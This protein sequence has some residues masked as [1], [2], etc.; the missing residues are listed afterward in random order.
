MADEAGSK[1]EDLRSVAQ[2]ALDDA[3]ELVRQYYREEQFLLC[4]I[5]LV[6]LGAEVMRQLI[7]LN[8]PPPPDPPF[9]F[10]A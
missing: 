10:K 1:L 2:R 3:L 4:A 6:K 8:H 5:L 9:P 7:P